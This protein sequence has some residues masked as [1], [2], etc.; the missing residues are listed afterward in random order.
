M[1]S[2]ELPEVTNM[3][4][5][6]LVIHDGRLKCELTGADMNAETIMK[7]AILKEGN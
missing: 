5:R 2:S 6:L 1:I 4:D 7:K 3:S